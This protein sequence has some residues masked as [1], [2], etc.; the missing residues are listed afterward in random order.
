MADRRCFHRKILESDSFRKLPA[1]TQILYVHLCMAA[2]DDGF[3]NNAESICGQGKAGRTDLNRLVSAR[4]LLKFGDV[5]VV[6]H[7]R[8]SNSLKNDRKKALTY[9]DIG[10]KIW[11][12]SNRGYTD[13][14]EEG[15]KTLLESKMESKRNPDGIQMESQPNRTEPNRTEPNRTEPNRSPSEDFVTMV[16]QYPESR[17]GSLTQA[18]E[19]FFVEI[20]S[21]EDFVAAMDNLQAWKRSEQWTKDGGQYIP[22]LVNW[23]ERGIWNTKP[24]EANLKERRDLDEDELEAI[25]RMM[26]E[27]CP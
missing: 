20:L 14:P 24:P 8:I 26:E 10:A 2:D 19:A 21:E 6:K 1:T 13:H 3:I 9:P 16:S 7:W 4:F 23:L 12:Q 15:C 5:Y 17:R 18:Q 11:I 22:Y 25:R 27:E